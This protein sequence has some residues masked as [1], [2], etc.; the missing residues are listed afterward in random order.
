MA[1]GISCKFPTDLPSFTSFNLQ[2]SNITNSIYSNLYLTIPYGSPGIAQLVSSPGGLI[3]L[4]G[5]IQQGCNRNSG[6]AQVVNNTLYGIQII[7]NSAGRSALTTFDVDANT[8]E[9]NG[10]YGPFQWTSL[11]YVDKDVDPLSLYIT[12][13]GGY[14]GKS[15]SLPRFWILDWGVERQVGFR[16]LRLTG[17]L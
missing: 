3:W 6:L 7:P 13:A 10:N 9:G 11:F 4:D 16:N 15:S 5:T 17:H 2:V 1:G 12:N 8:N 14:Y